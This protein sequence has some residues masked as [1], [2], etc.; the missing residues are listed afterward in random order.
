MLN[1]ALGAD[2]GGNAEEAIKQV[3]KLVDI[4]KLK[5]TIGLEQGLIKV[6]SVINSLGAASSA[7]EG[8]LVEFTKRL[9][10]IAPAA[11]IS[12]TDVLALG[13]TLDQLGI[14]AEV[15]STAV[16]QFL[17]SIGKDVP[18]FAKVAGLSVAEF[19][20]MLR[21]DANKA[22][23]TVLKGLEGSTGS[24]EAMSKSLSGLGIDGAQATQS[25][26]VLAQNVS[27]LEK[28]QALARKEFEAG[29]SILNEFA[30][31]NNN[32]A[33]VVEKIQKRLAGM[34]INSAFMKGLESVLILFEKAIK[35][36]QDFTEGLRQQEL[37]LKATQQQ[38]NAEMRVLQAGNLTT[39]QRNSL[40]AEMNEK[41][42]DILPQLITEKTT[43]EELTAIQQKSNEVLMQK[44]ILKAQE[45][46]LTEKLN[47]IVDLERKQE[48]DRMRLI[49]AEVEAEKAREGS[50]ERAARSLSGVDFKREEALQKIDA[51]KAA[52]KAREEEIARIQVSIDTEDK[53]FKKILE[54][55]GLVATEGLNK[56]TVAEAA[57]PAATAK[58]TKAP[59]TIAV[60]DSGKP[61]EPSKLEQDIDRTIEK[62]Q[63]FQEKVR[64]AKDQV[65]AS[66]ESDF[67][68]EL[69][70]IDRRYETLLNEARTFHENMKVGDMEYNEAIKTLIDT[71]SAEVQAKVKA[72]NEKLIAENEAKNS[73]ALQSDLEFWGAEADAR[74][75]AMEQEEADR[76]KRLQDTADMYNTMGG[77]LSEF[78]SLLSATNSLIAT[79]G[80]TQ[81]EFQKQLALV[82]IGIDTAVSISKAIAGATA[83][84][85]AT[86]PAAP[87]TLAGYMLSMVT[88]VVS[89]YA[90]AKAMLDKDAPKAPTFYYGGHTG[91]GPAI[92]YDQY[93]K[94]VGGVHKNE[95]VVNESLLL[96]NPW[97]ANQVAIIDALR[98]GRISEPPAMPGQAP[99][100]DNA[101]MQA[102]LSRFDRLESAVL[103]LDKP[104][105]A[106]FDRDE[107]EAMRR[108]YEQEDSNRQKSRL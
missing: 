35:A 11:D 21:E 102:L 52:V 62:W 85:A 73:K 88:A 22:L 23:I 78:S 2:F 28:Q 57:K 34:F 60:T 91:D 101:M 79:Q 105:R 87:F 59:G 39:A 25:I 100:Q 66:G 24:L 4:F 44:I 70:E 30:V 55:K 108:Y 95:Y 89:G 67:Q 53:L 98:V 6:G 51:I 26:G 92:G 13:A 63:Q 7:A 48:A 16:G 41:Y 1:V 17:M 97:V 61:A 104:Y 81:S 47:K 75:A 9:G 45:A 103:S 3:G 84:A 18:K 8:Y 27:L 64:Q 46:D 80:E 20:K 56:F 38:F 37:Q 96:G 49:Q 74:R 43:N 94:I 65:W 83:A 15:G 29:S 54:R 31:K 58:A 50:G 106:Y 93:G 5:D 42:K 82:Q 19:S 36:E 69:T 86:G 68:A 107:S 77:L 40:I 14:T 10:G 12:S 76:Q 99:S 72:M 90:Q 33:A 71:H 32:L